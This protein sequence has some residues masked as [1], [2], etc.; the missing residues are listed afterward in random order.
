MYPLRRIEKRRPRREVWDSGRN[1]RLRGGRPSRW[2]ILE[3]RTLLAT[4][5]PSVLTVTDTSDNVTDPGSLRGAIAL[6]PSGG[7]IVFAPSLAGKTITLTHGELL[8]DKNLT[9][10]GLGAN[11]L[12]ISGNSQSRVFEVASGRTVSLSGLTITSGQAKGGNGG[13]IENAGTL[14][15]SQSTI[16]SGTAYL[17]GGIDNTASGM[18]TVTATTFSGN[19][20]FQGAGLA[21]AG[22]ATVVDST[23]RGNIAINLGGGIMNGPSASGNATSGVLSLVNDTISNN[24]AG[25]TYVNDGGGV[26]QAALGE[27]SLVNTIIAGNIGGDV[28]DAPGTWFTSLGNNL[29]GQVDGSLGWS[30]ADLTGTAQAPLS[31]MLGPLLSNGG[32]TQTMALLAGSPA[33]GT[34]N[35]ALA[36]ATDERGFSRS[37]Q[38]PSDIGAYEYDRPLTLTGASLAYTQGVAATQTIASFLGTDSHSQAGDFTATIAWGDGSTSTVSA[39]EGGIVVDARGGFDVAAGHTYRTTGLFAVKVTINDQDGGS[40]TIQSVAA[41]FGVNPTSTSP[42]TIA[43]SPLT[44]KVGVLFSG[45]VATVTATDARVPTGN[46]SAVISW[47]DGNFSV[48]TVTATGDGAYSVSGSH[49]YLHAGMNTVMVGVRVGGGNAALAQGQAQVAGGTLTDT[50]PTATY[51]AN[52]G[53]DTG[54]Q[55]LAT[56]TDSNPNATLADF[57]LSVNWGGNISGSPW[58]AIAPVSV[59][60]GVSTWKVLG[61]A[62]YSG[63]G[64][65]RVAV[66]VKDVNGSTFSSTKTAFKVVSTAGSEP[67]FPVQ[68]VLTGSIVVT[69]TPASNVQ[70][71]LGFQI[72]SGD[73]E[74]LLGVSPPAGSSAAV[75]ETLRVP[76]T[77]GQKLLIQVLGQ[78][79]YG[80]SLQLS[81]LDQYQTPNIQTLFV[82]TQ[83]DPSSIAVAN[84]DGKAPDIIVSSTTDS[85]AINVLLNNGDGTFQSASSY[86]V[87]PGLNNDPSAGGRPITVADLTQDGGTDL[88]IPNALAGDLSVLVG[89]GDGSFQ[90]QRRFDALSDPVAVVSGDFTGQ[91][92]TDFAV[93]QGVAQ[94]G[95]NLQFAVLLGRPDGTLSTPTLYT[96]NFAQDAGSMVVGDFT[97]NGRADIIIFSKDAPVAQIFY[98]NG[99][100]T[101]RDGGEFST[102]DEV[103]AASVADLNGDGK[104]DLIL[105]GESS[106]QVEVLLG[107]GDGTFQAPHSYLVSSQSSSGVII[108]GLDIV[109]F[110]SASTAS[111]LGIQIGG[112]DGHLDIIV[113]AEPADGSGTAQVIMLPGLVDSQ[114]NYAGFGNPIVLANVG[115]AGQI[116]SG[117]F[118]RNGITDLAVTDVGGVTFIFGKPVTIPSNTTPQT[119]RN[120][121]SS[122]HVA[123]LPEIITP[124]YEDEYYTFRVPTESVA[125]SGDQV[126]DFSAL[127]SSAN[128]V[129]LQLEVTNGAGA[130]LGVGSRFRVVAAQGEVLTVHV[131]GQTDS[132]GVR[133]IGVYSLNIDVL[134][135]VVSV[136]A[137]SILPGGPVTS[138]VLT[139]QGDR[140]NPVAAQNPANYTVTWYSPDGHT[141]QV[142]PLSGSGSNAVIY[143]PSADLGVASG[144]HY[145]SA[146]RQTV[147]LLFGRALPAGTYVI[148]LSP[149][150]TS[151]DFLPGAGDL[152]S[153][154]AI[155]GGHSVVSRGAGNTI[156]NGAVLVEA[157]LVTP[158]APSTDFGVLAQG[159]PFLMQLQNDLSALVD[160]LRAAGASPAL[161]TDALNRQ[162]QARFAPTIAALATSFPMA[163]TI[164]W[165]DPV[166]FDLE[167]PQGSGV[168]YNQGTNAYS[169]NLGQTYVSVGG[170][171]ELVVL[172]NVAGSFNL[173]V[174]NVSQTSAGGAVLLTPGYSQSI[175]FTNSFG[176]LNGPINFALTFPGPGAQPSGGGV[177]ASGN[178]GGGIASGSASGALTSDFAAGPGNLASGETQLAAAVPIGGVPQLSAV[179][180]T[181]LTVA[182]GVGTS[183]ASTT[184]GGPG[185]SIAP[186]TAIITNTADGADL[187][188]KSSRLWKR[189]LANLNKTLGGW[190]EAGGG[191]RLAYARTSL[192]LLTGAGALRRALGRGGPFEELFWNNVAGILNVDDVQ[193]A[194]NSN[195][196]VRPQRLGRKAPP[197]QTLPA[198]DL[199]PTRDLFSAEMAALLWDQGLEGLVGEDPLTERG[200][201]DEAP[202]ARVY[203]AALL[204]GL[205]GSHLHGRR[206]SRRRCR[207]ES[208]ENMQSVLDVC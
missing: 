195:K 104:L 135:Q 207:D 129:G 163:F 62:V 134:P 145:S 59:S 164:L 199:S 180:A 125:G 61:N 51:N 106:G 157:N 19:I 115:K 24:K 98:G 7:T 123:T 103:G 45:V 130:V 47:G 176:G 87:G 117:D 4:V 84:L 113:T 120:L 126:V 82:P 43:V 77:Q 155:F 177:E 33:I 60:G 186:Q 58:I 158:M 50:S 146:S 190:V 110:G 40:S 41:V 170:N 109:D 166:S 66:T 132:A 139:F 57:S 88:V 138:L 38:G 27:L 69:L 185:Q 97:G 5:V 99:D 30:P 168:A 96:T 65:Y 68:A 16:A 160:A 179:L 136:Q 14:S 22:T 21:S 202:H 25:V 127:F 73:G 2:E 55:V 76:V 90:P 17:G 162:I 147:T 128:G 153:G 133:G 169:N 142:I 95:S 151:A 141:I 75:T 80:Y 108:G 173:Q 83:G 187:A 53:Y 194:V 12:T 150:L 102:G 191:R 9:I 122:Q 118:A 42:A 44:A 94:A 32:P 39:S 203:G 114:G 208:E 56:F 119:A 184:G 78:G 101:F 36:P 144:L 100:G 92:D 152:L 13:N 182:P 205:A 31:P 3:E 74:Q 107:N 11:S 71:P 121:G 20:G 111:H 188:A 165:F 140:L 197:Q 18:L 26:Y 159:T 70:Q 178:S 8:L 85:D 23:F 189:F 67:V 52:Q 131:F 172:G 6:A 28:L 149:S 29:I 79:S 91:G 105:A 196:P 1:G 143:D 124:G 63:T 137:E 204:L 161:I 174:S 167:T 37:A 181:S 193:Q 34:G 48:G 156:A 171:V 49:T 198:A 116:A 112:A 35:S 148:A 81:Y 86:N 93:L 89:N 72:F 64:S 10:S 54:T 201:N 183:T 175:S 46:F 200:G 192:R 154:T 15:V 206:L